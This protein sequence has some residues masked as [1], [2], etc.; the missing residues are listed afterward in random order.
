M[1]VGFLEW[2]PVDTRVGVS[3]EVTFVVLGGREKVEEGRGSVHVVG[4][5]VGV[6][7]GPACWDGV[8]VGVIGYQQ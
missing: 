1:V 5:L 7:G 8:G 6:L 2:Y 3:A 4:V